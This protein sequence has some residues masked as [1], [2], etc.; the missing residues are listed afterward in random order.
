M[1]G[2][3]GARLR[4]LT[5]VVTAF[6]LLTGCSRPEQRGK[7]AVEAADDDDDVPAKK[8]KKKAKVD[9]DES[10][11][12]DE[13]VPELT[14]DDKT[15]VDKR[16]GWGWSDRCWSSLGKNKLGNAIAECEE[17][18]K[19]APPNG[20]AKPAL[21]YNR[22]LIEERLGHQAA[23]RSYFEKSLDL[24]PANDPGR[25]EV[26][27][28]LKRVGG[29]P[30]PASAKKSKSKEQACIDMCPS[31]GMGHCFCVCMGTCND[32]P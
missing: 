20:D 8:K 1:T 11:K 10:A 22:G 29:V 3:R 31:G 15:F 19:I 16:N 17:G 21:L 4:T 25:K 18:L 30:K 14:A 28:A 23:A 12:G 32:D 24:R 13:V 9:E 26:E 27:Q 7:G 2:V 6:A 5:S